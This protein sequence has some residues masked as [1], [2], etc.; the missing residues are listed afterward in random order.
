LLAAGSDAGAAD[1]PTT[2]VAPTAEAS[3]A[4]GGRRTPPTPMGNDQVYGASAASAAPVLK[5]KPLPD[6]DP[7]GNKGPH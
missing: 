7:W 4:T 2:A 1:T 3:A 5:K 6:D